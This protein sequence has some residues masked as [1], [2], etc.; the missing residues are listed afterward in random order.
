[1]VRWLDVLFSVMFAVIGLSAFGGAAAIA[2]QPPLASMPLGWVVSLIF[3]TELACLGGV[4]WLLAF[5]AWPRSAACSVGG[6]E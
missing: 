6:C 3:C 5:I 4:A 1:M 2:A